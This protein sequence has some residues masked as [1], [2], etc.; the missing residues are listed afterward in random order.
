MIFNE[1]SVMD[2]VTYLKQIPAFKKTDCSVI[3]KSIDFFSDIDG[4]ILEE[5]SPWVHF[6]EFKKDHIICR[7]GKFNE[8][9]YILLSGNAHAT[10]P[11]E[12]NPRYVLYKLSP[13]SFFGGGVLF[14]FLSRESTIAAVEDICAMSLNAEALRLL[15]NKSPRIKSLLDEEYISRKLQRDLRRM[16]VFTMLNE[17]IFQKMITKVELISVSKNE[18]IFKQGD[19][20]DALYLIRD[21]EVNV[22]IK[23][24]TKEQ[25][26]AILG[27]GQFFGEMA[28]LSNDKRNAT[29]KAAKKSELVKISR[30]VFYEIIKEEKNMLE[31][32]QIAVNE[33]KKHEKIALENPNMA[34]ITRR[35]IDLNREVTA[36]LNIISEC[37][38]DT[39]SGSALLA[40]LPGSRY[41][42][43]YPRDSA[44]ASR[45]LYAL[46]T[47][48]LKSGDIAFRLLGEI[49]RFIHNCQRDDGYW[50]QRYGINGND[51]GI[52]KQEDNVAHGVT[53]LCRYL[54]AAKKRDVNIHQFADMV[55]SIKKG[56]TYALRNYYRNEIHLFYS[57]T[58]IHESALEE[59]YSIWV[60]Y[61]YLLMLWLIEDVCKEYDLKG[62]FEEEKNLR[63]G[64]ETTIGNILSL[65]KR[66][67]RRLKPDGVVDLRPDITLLSPFF[68]GTGMETE[69]FNNDE[70]FVNTI[71]FVE[72]TLWDPHLG[73]LQRY[74]PFIEDPHTHIHAGNGPWLPYTAMLAQYYFYSGNL[75][76]GNEI[77]DIIDTY[78]TKE[79]YL[80][81]HLTTSER[82]NE[83][84]RLEWNPGRDQE[85]EFDPETLVDNISYDNILEELNHMRNAYTDVEKQ[86]SKVGDKGYITFATTFAT[87]L[88]WAHAEYA[89]ALMLKI[90]KE[91]DSL[92]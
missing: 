67:V 35:L 85:K 58:S 59:G 5:I 18:I 91:I 76:R 50:G 15:I 55:E 72:D 42:F 27:E 81:E 19:E 68:F 24:E 20:G 29:L 30:N 88:M 61:A 65:S 2:L 9:F 25:L 14:P 60:N 33:R 46:S 1:Y 69:H 45:F 75:K 32:M 31:D 73:M 8:K 38:I 48:D 21:G 57:T 53:I 89:M 77:I 43:V 79:G 64:F 80:C 51:K 3:L 54:L 16:P 49:S 47:S 23:K 78:K 26:I 13:G 22:F 39:D 34:V 74:L 62:H 6:C 63:K 40:S 82:F 10:I 17:T 71:H 90:Q 36:H 66:Y 37:T 28:L 44:C 7:H 83:F 52:Y 12:N 4:K 11:T 41:P 86:S 87:P 70:S 84:K 56:A 92:S